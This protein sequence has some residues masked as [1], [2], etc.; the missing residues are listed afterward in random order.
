[1]LFF[2][3]LFLVFIYLRFS[4]IIR[5]RS[6]VKS[7]SQLPVDLF[8]CFCSSSPRISVVED[9][10]RM[11]KYRIIKEKLTRIFRENLSGWLMPAFDCC[12]A[13]NAARWKMY[14]HAI[15]ANKSTLLSAQK[16]VSRARAKQTANHLGS[17]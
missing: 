9:C 5:W 16:K 10:N 1:M 4:S 15:I 13:C 3:S 8:E 6:F 2:S 12:S 17:R 14:V 11:A 7:V